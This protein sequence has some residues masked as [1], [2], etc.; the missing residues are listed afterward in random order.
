MN[1]PCYLVNA[2]LHKNS[3]SVYQ[4]LSRYRAIYVRDR[5]S[6]AE[7]NDAGLTGQYVPDLTFAG[8]SE[9]GAQ[10][11]YSGCVIDSAVKEDRAA[12]SAYAKE[13][14]L[15]YRSMIVARPGN[16]KF[17]RSPRPYV[18]N[19]YHWLKSERKISLN[20]DSYI[21][22]LRQYKLVVTGRYHT[23][24][25]CVKNKIPFV[26]LESNT[27][28][29]NS[30]LHDIFSDAHRSMTMDDVKKIDLNKGIQFSEK[31]IESINTFCTDAES[32][33]KK[34]IKGISVDIASIRSASYRY[35]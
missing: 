14:N 29:V 4:L 23:V 19:I 6:L 26:A 16:A 17:L 18:K 21:S 12:L 31:E 27:P 10:G 3:E 32:S 11:N 1:T 13:N 15:P 30:L 7:L 25:M 2:T 35:D 33:I 34:M 9:Y 28:K 22:Y 24:T 5:K 8:A 20:P